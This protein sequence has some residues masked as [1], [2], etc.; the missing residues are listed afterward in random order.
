MNDQYT[1][2]LGLVVSVLFF[3][4]GWQDRGSGPGGKYVGFF[5]QSLAVFIAVCF[6]IYAIKH[7]MLSGII[8]LLL[9][10]IT[11][12]WFMKKTYWHS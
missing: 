11:E 8:A 7:R 1:F 4:S 12:L 3:L 2:L 10:S 6:C 5:S 9:L